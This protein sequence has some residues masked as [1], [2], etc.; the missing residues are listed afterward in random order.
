MLKKNILCVLVLSMLI[1]IGVSAQTLTTKTE[2]DAKAVTTQKKSPKAPYVSQIKLE[3][4]TIKKNHDTNQVIKDDI[5]GEIAQVKT[6]IAQDKA[7]KTLKSKKEAITA[8]RVVIKADRDILEGININLKA[9]RNTNKTDIAN[10]DYAT[11]VNDLNKIAPLQTSK[12]P[13][14]QK[15]SSDLD[16]LISL[17]SN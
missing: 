13:V 3:R 8:Q 15:I 2:P 16:T 10:K 9:N 14:L 5:K 12:T 6:L 11:L 17:F 1:P 4:E 7:N